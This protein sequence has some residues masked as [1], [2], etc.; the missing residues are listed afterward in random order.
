[1][2]DPADSNKA[3]IATV[4][5]AMYDF[6]PDRVR[7]ALGETCA[8]D[9]VFHHCAPFGD[10]AGPEGFFDGALAGL[11]EAWPDLERRDYIRIAGGTER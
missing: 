3:R 8:P 9:A 4:A 10:L 7:A 11:S 5:E 6:A 1:M 2:S